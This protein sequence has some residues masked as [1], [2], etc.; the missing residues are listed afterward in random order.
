[1]KFAIRFSPSL[2]QNTSELHK[3]IT[4]HGIK[5]VLPQEEI[6]KTPSIIIAVRRFMKHLILNPVTSPF[7]RQERDVHGLTSAQHTQ[8][9]IYDSITRFQSVVGRIPIFGWVA[10]PLMSVIKGFFDTRLPDGR[11]VSSLGTV[12]PGLSPGLTNNLS[13]NDQASFGQQQMPWM[14]QAA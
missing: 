14:P 1:M 11:K 3:F 9:N 10:S 13:I 8:K 4:Q 6:M 7:F 2:F 5:D 12:K